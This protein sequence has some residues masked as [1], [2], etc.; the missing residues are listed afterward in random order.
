MADA[1]VNVLNSVRAGLSDVLRDIHSTLQS[2]AG[3]HHL[4]NE[5][6]KTIT[7]GLRTDTSSRDSRAVAIEA[8]SAT[9][10]PAGQQHMSVG[11]VTREDLGRSTW[12]LLHTLAAQYPG[13]PSK[14][15]RK[16]VAALVATT[17]VSLA[18]LLHAAALLVSLHA[19]VQQVDTLTRIYP[20]GECAVHFR[21][22]VRYVSA[23]S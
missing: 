19:C 6:A 16:D 1:V 23:F 8:A 7:N 9:A 14:Q 12:L 2:K 18:K 11:P 20:C 5:H 21:D 3:S 15:Q 10:L 17:S 13:R 4:G 22:I